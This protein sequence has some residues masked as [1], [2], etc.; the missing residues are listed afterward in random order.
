MELLMR[1]LMAF[2]FAHR[3]V[4]LWASWMGL[5]LALQLDLVWVAGLEVA[6]DLSQEQMWALELAGEK[7]LELLVRLVQLLVIQLDRPWWER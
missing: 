4:I 1:L 3:K 7:V 2:L 6:L 5:A